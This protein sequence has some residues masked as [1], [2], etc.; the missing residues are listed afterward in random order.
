MSDRKL[1]TPRA[2]IPR[3]R[4][5]EYGVLTP[6]VA[7][8]KRHSLSPENLRIKTCKEGQRKNG[9]MK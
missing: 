3:E 8:S 4:E 2:T 5:S 9:S 1:H 6:T 7:G